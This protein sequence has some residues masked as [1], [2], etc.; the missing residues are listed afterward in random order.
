MLSKIA[1]QGV[2]S[3]QS[4]TALET[5]TKVNIV[6]GLNGTGKSTLSNF[7]YNPQAAGYEQCSV[8]Q[9]ADEAVLVYNQQF[10]QDHFY[11]ADSLKGI[12]SLSKENKD[13]EEK[14][15]T[16]EAELTDLQQKE[17]DASK[18]ITVEKTKLSDLKSQT[19][20]KLFEIKQMYAGGDRVLEYCLDRRKNKEPLFNYMLGLSKP[21]IEPSKNVDQIKSEVEAIN[22]ENAQEYKAYSALSFTEHEVEE[23]EIFSELIVGN[24]DSPAASLI[25][26]LNN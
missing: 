20:N 3:Y 22:G 12:F 21:E 5:D 19:Q 17:E 23:S 18:S 13:I 4:L 1:L 2:A 14:I 16:A 10:I 9:S 26:K 7:L 11:E 8:D 24:N 15:K 25:T 6:Y